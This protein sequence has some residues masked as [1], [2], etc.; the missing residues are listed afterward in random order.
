MA[1]PDALRYTKIPLGHGSGGSLVR[2]NL[3]LIVS[4]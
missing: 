1:S 2:L 4:P 3:R